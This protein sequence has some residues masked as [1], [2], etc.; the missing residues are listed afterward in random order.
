MKKLTAIILAFMCGITC[1]AQ[2][3]A[4]YVLSAT[5]TFS[6]NSSGSISYTMGEM[7]M[8]S[9]FSN[10]GYILTQGFQQGYPSSLSSMLGG[11]EALPV[12]LV[13]FSGYNSDG[14]NHLHWQTAS[15]LDNYGFDVQRI[16][17]K[18]DFESI[19]FVKGVGTSS[20]THDYEMDDRQPLPGENYYRL[21]QEDVD[22]KYTYSDIISINTIENAV[23]GLSIYPIPATD[24]FN[25]LVY[26][27]ENIAGTITIT[28]I[29]GTE[30]YNGP[31]DIEAGATIAR[32]DLSAFAPGQYLVKL[33]TGT[34]TRTTHIV[35][36]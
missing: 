13:G 12:T 18:G 19:G 8:V 24:H 27:T 1:F 23:P 34:S 14:I 28:D 36:Q 35:K 2:I 15:E 9:T 16:N 11:A 4:Y 6:Q 22:G 32:I 7:S 21:K 31:I 5:G 17:S 33:T 20:G 10:G 25:L 26:G 30:F 3:N 29:I